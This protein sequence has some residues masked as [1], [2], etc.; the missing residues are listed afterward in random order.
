MGD[1]QDAG[2]AA[3]GA[4]HLDAERKPQVIDATGQRSS[5]RQRHGWS[6]AKSKPAHV[7]RHLLAVD[8]LHEQ[9]RMGER[10]NGRRWTN[11]HV[12]LLEER[13]EA[14]VEQ[15]LVHVRPAHVTER[16]L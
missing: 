11:Q 3:V 5:T 15:G 4:D 13:E 2:V 12:Y 1:L 9:L 14:L 6:I 10:R 16:E 7:C 8:F